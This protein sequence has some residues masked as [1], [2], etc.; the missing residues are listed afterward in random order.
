MKNKVRINLPKKFSDL[1]E[2]LPEQGMGYQIVDIVLKN[3]KSLT[4][5]IVLNS[6]I[7]E[8]EKGEEIKAKEI[9]TIKL[10]SK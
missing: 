5:K 7:L 2:N 4:K 8:L 9:D 1:L 6:S 3:G 10:H